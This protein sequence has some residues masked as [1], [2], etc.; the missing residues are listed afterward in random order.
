MKDALDFS[1]LH[2]FMVSHIYNLLG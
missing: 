2:A 1:L